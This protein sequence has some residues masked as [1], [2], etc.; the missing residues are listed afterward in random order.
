MELRRTCL[1]FSISRAI[2]GGAFAL[3][4]LIDPACAADTPPDTAAPSTSDAKSTSDDASIGVITVTA[5]SRSQ[6][7][8]AVPIAMQLVTSDQINKLAATNIGE[9]NGYIPG[10][11]VDADQPT[12]P[13]YTL[14]GLGATDFGIG[15][16][17]P[18]GIYVDGVYTGKTGGALMNFNDIQRIEVLKGPQGTLFGR[19]LHRYQ[20]AIV[21]IRGR[22]ACACRPIRRALY[23]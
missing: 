1:A 9:L 21:R 17:G 11:V 8:Q 5:Q 20:G 18:V 15:T 22:R 23:G 3:G 6:Q 12:Q 4:S 7:A 13:N 2:L 14:R 16:D 19:N 10:L